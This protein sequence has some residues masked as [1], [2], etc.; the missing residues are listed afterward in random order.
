MIR[1]FL[2]PLLACVAAS[3]APC[4]KADPSCTEWLQFGV[5][6]ARS[7]IYRTFSLDTRN[8]S[9]TRALIVVH[10]AG[11]DA[12][13]YFRS[14]LAAA[15]LGGALD[16][17]VVIAPR[18]ASNAAN[19]KDTLAANEVSWNCNTWR[20]GGPAISNPDLTSFDFLDE[21][22]RKVARKEIFPNLKA[23]VVAGHSAGGQ[24]V[25]R[26]EMGNQVHEKLGVPVTYVV[27]NPSSYAYPEALRPTDAAYSVQAH[28][29]SYVP[30]IPAKHG[31][32]PRLQRQSRLHYVRPVALRPSETH[33][34]HRK[35]E[36]RTTEETV[37]RA[38][39]NLLA[40]RTRCAAAGRLRRVVSR[41]GAG[42]YQAGARRGV[43]QAGERET[44]RAPYRHHRS[45]VRA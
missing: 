3:A 27:S 8:E 11:R 9:I 29:P 34:L 24:V 31:A 4:I 18:M 13:N 44:G 12:D 33:G 28:P 23:I 5:G 22:L 10:G 39:Y 43:R 42:T 17:T 37:G 14:S 19:C 40:R 45:G 1:L 21:I 32:I 38:A 15:F 16:N 36:R 35:R 26:Y 7:L 25:N 20:S 2:A 30:E 6:P 41:H